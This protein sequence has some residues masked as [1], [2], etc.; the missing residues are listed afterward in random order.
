[1]NYLLERVTPKC[2]EILERCAWKGSL[3]RCD[4]LFQPINSSEGVCCSFNNYAFPTSNYDQKIMSSIPKEPRRVTACGYQTGLSLLLK[5]NPDDYVGTE[6]ASSGFRVGQETLCDKKLL[7][8]FYC[9]TNFQLQLMVHNSYDNADPN[10]VTK[11]LPS[12]SEAYL[13]I[14]PES[15]YSTDDVFQLAPDLRNC[16]KSDERNMDTFAKYSYVNCVAEC[17]SAIVNFYCGCVPYN[18]PNNGTSK[19]QCNIYIHS[20]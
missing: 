10:A 13:S 15:T 6:I 4:S 14:A 12:K 8:I 16:L 17:R 3:W 7:K 20:I 2:S 19:T 11:L 1:M 5:P 18:L 9:S